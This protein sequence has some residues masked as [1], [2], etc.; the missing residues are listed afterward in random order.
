[1]EIDRY[2][3]SRPAYVQIADWLRRRIESG[4]LP[5]GQA[6][7]SKRRVREELA[8]S[9]ETYDKAVRI[10]KAEGLVRTAWGLGHIVQEQ[11]EP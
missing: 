4:E 10:L 9:G 6:I 3:R 1:V 8:V 11:R 5:P 2:D 7:P